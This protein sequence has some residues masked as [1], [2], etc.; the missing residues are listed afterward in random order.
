VWMDAPARR[1]RSHGGRMTHDEPFW[2]HARWGSG[3]APRDPA[4]NEL[5]DY[6]FEMRGPYR[7]GALVDAYVEWMRY[8]TEVRRAWLEAGGHDPDAEVGLAVSPAAE[9]RRWRAWR[10]AQ[11]EDE[12]APRSLRFGYDGEWSPY[13]TGEHHRT[14][15]EEFR[16]RHRGRRVR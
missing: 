15:F 14:P 8:R 16:G 9:L 5:H 7:P 1:D 13:L 12:A 3:W 11:R 4:W 2:A 6:D 10:R